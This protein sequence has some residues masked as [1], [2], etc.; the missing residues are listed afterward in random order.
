MVRTL[1]AAAK[2]LRYDQQVIAALVIAMAIRVLVDLVGKYAGAGDNPIF[3]TDADIFADALK[4]GL[5]ER[6]VSLPLLSDPRVA[7]WPA[8]FQQYLFYNPYLGPDM[9]IHAQAPLGTLQLMAVAKAIVLGSPWMALG[10]FVGLYCLGALLVVRLV[11]ACAAQPGARGTLALKLLLFS[12]PALFMF[13]RGNF[14]SGFASIGVVIYL[15]SA[16]AGRYRWAGV[17]AMA[18]AI[19][20]RPNVALITIAEFACN[21]TLWQALRLQIAMAV[22]AGVTGLAALMAAHAIDPQYSLQAF[23]QG[24]ATYR[25]NYVLHDD[26]LGWNDSLYGAIRAVR[27]LFGSTPSYDPGAS[28]AVTCLALLVTGGFVWLALTRRLARVEAIFVALAVCTLFT[29]VYGQYHI[30]VFAAPVLIFALDSGGRARAHGVGAF[31]PA[32]VML[33]L[34]CM[35]ASYTPSGA[36]GIILAGS[37]VLVAGL[38]WHMEPQKERGSRSE[39]LI[40][41]ASL[42]ALS[43]VGGAISNGLAIA[44]LL[45]AAVCIV[46]LNASMRPGALARPIDA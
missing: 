46:L 10:I 13:D 30:L 44:A 8:L 24:Y 12:Y 28:N 37:S 5:A 38:L 22:A 20:V 26:G 43:P 29:P 6:A 11:G 19:N 33:L 9:L 41:V 23:L 15:I 39:R 14:H 42:L 3:F 18:Y 16:F 4:S 2:Q 7:H 32:Y 21:E 27:S 1:L 36:I 31:L 25:H 45:F 17:V 34:P 35:I 40:L